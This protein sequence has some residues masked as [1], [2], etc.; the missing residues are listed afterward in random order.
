MKKI[1]IMIIEAVV[2]AMATVQRGT[3]DPP[4]WEW[5]MA[6]TN[7]VETLGLTGKA[8]ARFI[9]GCYAHASPGG[10]GWNPE[11]LKYQVIPKWRAANLEGEV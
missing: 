5:E 9:L 3:E 6:V 2:L 7:L 8:R 4:G 11:L 10:E 1:E